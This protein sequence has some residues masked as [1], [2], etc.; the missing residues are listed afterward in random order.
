MVVG[1]HLAGK[2]IDATVNARVAIL[3]APIEGQIT[4]NV[5]NIGA[6]VVDHTPLADIV[7]DRFDNA[8]L[9]D[10]ERARDGLKTDLQRIDSQQAAINK[11]RAQFVTQAG[12]YQAGRVAQLKSRI[13][14]AQAQAD[15][16]AA[17]KKEAENALS[18]ANDLSGKGVQTAAT[19]DTAQSR[20]DVARL[21]LESARQRRNYLTTELES[22]QNGVFIGD[23]YNDEPFSLQRIKELDLRLAELTAEEAQL[24]QRLA[25]TGEQISAE[26]LRLNKLTAVTLNANADRRRVGFPGQ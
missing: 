20:F 26:K 18:R 9:I 22:A 4:L 11:T 21:D 2:T 24:K 14:E 1:E 23:F 8:R 7:D 25:L 5:R 17:R 19:L 13:A 6:R 12:D 3:R 15:A 10:L 16:G